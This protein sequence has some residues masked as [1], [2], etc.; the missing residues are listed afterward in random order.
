MNTALDS[1][2]YLNINRF[3]KQLLIVCIIILVMTILRGLRFPNIWSYSHMFF[4]YEFGFMRRGLIGAI[5]S[6]IDKPMLYTY[7]S[8]FYLS[9]IILLSNVVF[10]SLTFRDFIRSNNLNLTACAFIFA[11]SSGIIF[12]AHNIGYA[13]H[14]GLLLC[15]I[16]FRLKS[17]KNKLLF[18][19]PSL[20]LALMIHEAI[21]VI[22]FPILFISLTLS[23]DSQKNIKQI[24]VLAVFSL[25]A[26]FLFFFIGNSSISLE[27]AQAI[28][29]KAQGLSDSPLR[30][31]AFML[32]KQSSTETILMMSEK[33]S[34]PARIAF[35]FI[36]GLTIFPIAI[37]IQ[38]NM[39]S[40][41]QKSQ[42]SKVF[43]YLCVAGGLSPLLLHTVAW[44]TMRWNT[45]YIIT[46][47]LMCYTVLKQL[48]SEEAE[49]C[50]QAFFMRRSLPLLLL[51]VFL[52]ANAQVLL[53][54]NRRVENFPFP[55]HIS[56]ISDVIQGNTY[57]P[58]IP[59]PS[60]P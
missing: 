59:E 36:S 33:W 6:L 53:M 51:M 19:A 47:Y 57:F 40:L 13:D 23:L 22:F 5:L 37:Y 3:K 9:L 1:Q 8:H 28:L 58:E 35:L 30:E 32:L 46:A 43:I 49:K 25:Y 4:D 18:I 55:F 14:I 24:A 17:F 56:Y 12:L 27:Q 45:L 54:D 52:N 2:D 42:R 15:L 44:D 48:S 26:I 10:L 16:S 39:I 7:A 41:L 29:L 50:S 21:F 60:K 20:T 11:S 31:D 34:H 38:I